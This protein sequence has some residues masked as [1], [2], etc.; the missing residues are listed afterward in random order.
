M[1]CE[2]HSDREF[3]IP[4]ASLGLGNI[5]NLAPGQ[6]STTW[7]GLSGPEP[8]TLLV[9]VWLTWMGGGGLRLRREKGHLYP[10]NTA[11]T[12]TA[13]FPPLPVPPLHSQTDLL[14][15]LQS[16]PLTTCSSGQDVL[17]GISPFATAIKH[18]VL[19][20]CAFWQCGGPEG[21]GCYC[22]GKILIF[23]GNGRLENFKQFSNKKCFYK[24]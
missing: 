14:V 3:W 17:S 7:T 20:E 19:L 9:Q 1:E 23:F 10:I 12:N 16:W 8:A 15:P 21:A 13:P 24:F 18:V 5:C 4:E 11:T 22:F 6:T 2:L